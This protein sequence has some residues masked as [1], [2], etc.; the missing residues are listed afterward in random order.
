MQTYDLIIDQNKK[1][2]TSHGTVNFPLAIYETV[3]IRNFLGF[4]DWH[5]HNEIQLVLITDGDVEFCIGTEKEVLCA[6][7]ILFINTSILHSAKTIHGNKGTYICLNFHP[8]L[9]L[10]AHNSLVD[11]N[12]IVPYIGDGGIPY[13]RFKK[14]SDEEFE[15]ANIIKHIH[16]CYLEKEHNFSVTIDYFD[17]YLSVLSI[18]KN[19]L[20]CCFLKESRKEHT[21]RDDTVIQI[22]KYIC[23]HYDEKITLKNISVFVN[24]SVSTC[25]RKFR[26]HMNCSIFSYLM[27][28]RLQKSEIMLSKTQLSITDIALQCGFGSPSYYILHFRK[29]IGISP[30]QYRKQKLLNHNHP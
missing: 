17:I 3:I 6:G 25:S 4:V 29:T 12:Y 19:L 27:T 24:A 15:T 22:I 2:M 30:E 10:H 13:F 7:E 23:N 8:L 18:W 11:S 9:L 5:W 26:S 16:S 21:V 28:Y 1:D 14:G 20:K